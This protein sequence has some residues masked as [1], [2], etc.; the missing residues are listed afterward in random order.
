MVENGRNTTEILSTIFW[1]SYSCIWIDTA[2]SIFQLY[3]GIL[4]PDTSV[5]C[6]YDRNEIL[7]KRIQIEINNL[8]MSSCDLLMVNE[9][10]TLIVHWAT[11]EW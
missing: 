9:I 6:T 8:L 3:F 7:K 5:C 4:R 2:V 11:A 10:E 1:L